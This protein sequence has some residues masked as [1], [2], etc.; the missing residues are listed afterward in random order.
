MLSYY[1]NRRVFP[2]FPRMD[3]A[4]FPLVKIHRALRSV[5]ENLELMS[6]PGVEHINIGSGWQQ[7]LEITLDITVVCAQTVHW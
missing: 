1:D 2:K 6:V 3:E 5:Y 7:K 4:K